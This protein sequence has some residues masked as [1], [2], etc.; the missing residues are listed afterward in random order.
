MTRTL[1]GTSAVRGPRA[2]TPA[3]RSCRIRARPGARA[4]APR[5]RALRHRLQQRQ[6]GDDRQIDRGIAQRA[7]VELVDERDWAC[8]CPA[9]APARRAVPRGAAPHRRSGRRH[10]VFQACSLC[11][12]PRSTPTRVNRGSAE[13]DHAIQQA[14]ARP[15]APSTTIAQRLSRALSLARAA[16]R[17]ARAGRCPRTHAASASTWRTLLPGKESSMRHW[18]THE[19][20]FV[21]VLEGEVVL[22]TDAGEQRLTAG[23]VRRL[24]GRQHGR[25]S[26]HQSQ[27]AA[28][29]LTSRSATATPRTAATTPIPTSTSCG[30]RRTPAGH[31]RAATVRPAEG[32][33]SV[34][35]A[36]Q[37]QRERYA[38][39]VP[40]LVGGLPVTLA[41]AV[42]EALASRSCRPC[43]RT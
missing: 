42:V 29:G 5:A 27:R 38:D 24:C 33:V 28:G 18:H 25:A 12:A 32:V 16:A 7:P 4:G 37:A 21:Y 23:H 2:R 14:G 8:R 20:E 34:R 40:D 43:S 22:R 36:R 15:A 19:D 35:R 31:S 11:H 41:D 10:R 13:D 9:A 30:V 3:R 17:G 6:R 26:A 1:A 39:L